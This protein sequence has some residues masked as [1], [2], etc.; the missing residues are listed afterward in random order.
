MN[1]KELILSENSIELVGQNLL[2]QEE[3]IT[4]GEDWCVD[5]VDDYLRIFYGNSQVFA[6][7]NATNYS[8]AIIPKCY[9]LM[10]L[11]GNSIPRGFDPL[12]LEA[13]GILRVQ[14]APLNLTGKDVICAFLDT[15][16]RYTEEVFLKSD[17]TSRILTIWDQT[18]QTGIPPEGFQYGSEY[19]TEEI[20]IALQQENPYDYVPVT[21]ENGHGT[22]LASITAGSVVESGRIFTG[23]APDADIA[24]VKLRQAKRY[25]REFYG[26]DEDVVCF[27]ETDIILAIEYL[28][29]LA[30]RFGKPVVICV[31]LGSSYG[32]HNGTSPLATYCSRVANRLNRALLI[33]TGNEGNTSHHTQGM[34]GEENEAIE[35]RVNSGVDAFVAEIWGSI[36]YIFTAS[37]RSPSGEISP[38]IQPHLYRQYAYRFLY[39]KTFLTADSVLAEASSGEQLIRLKF[40]NPSPGIWTIFLH[41]RAGQGEAPYHI[42]LPLSEFMTDSVYFLSPSPYTTLTEPSSSQHPITVAAYQDS[43]NS[44]FA[45][46]GR[47]YTFSENIKPDLAAPGVGV[48]SALGDVSGSGIATA[49]AS[50]AA[51]QYMEWA[52]TQQNRPNANTQTLKSF[53]LRGARRQ[54]SFTTPNREFGWGFLDI[55]N[56]FRQQS[57][58]V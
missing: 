56:S 45:P 55:E 17:G 22:I 47:G 33:C 23:A 25:L 30:V 15:G 6:P 27:S 53:L 58:T 36:S 42:W 24:V 4:A 16:I 41:N 29:K 26:I 40:Q 43:N 21:D 38:V 31:G 10:R 3:I 37:I 19:T 49:I 11:E 14:R 18:V 32:D 28:Q 39:D 35:I 44:V 5:I 50:G 12:S 7:L 2:P 52:V 54:E 34:V 51:A 9:G 1:C 20:N 57:G 8:Y 46:S 48:S 13:A